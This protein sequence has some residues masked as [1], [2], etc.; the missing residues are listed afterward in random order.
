MSKDRGGI[1]REPPQSETAGVFS[2]EDPTRVFSQL[3]ELGHGAFGA[4]YQAV[5][6][7]GSTVAIKQMKVS[8]G[9]ASEEWQEILKEV[10][11]L[12]SCRHEHILEYKGCYRVGLTVWLVMECCIGSV[13]DIMDVFKAPLSEDEIAVITTCVLK[14]LDYLHQNSRMHRDIKGG[15][16]L[17][18]EAGGVRLG[19]FGS[20]TM[21]E[22]ANSF[23]GS[24]YWMAPEVIVAM[25]SGTYDGKVD[26][27][28]LGITCIEMAQRKPP[29]FE[30]QAMS[31]LYHIPQSEPPTLAD[32]AAWSVKFGEFVA[33]CL[34]MD[35]DKR[36]TSAALLEHEFLRIPRKPKVLQSLAARAKDP[37]LLQDNQ[38]ALERA[39]QQAASVVQATTSLSVNTPSSSSSNP[40]TAAPAETAT[41]KTK[42]ADSSAAPVSAP[43]ATSEATSAAAVAARAIAE[44]IAEELPPV[45]N[46]LAAKAKRMIETP[47]Q[48]ARSLRRKKNQKKQVENEL[49]VKQL[50]EIKKIR[51][52]QLQ[53]VKALQT[54]QDTDLIRQ[55]TADTREY[56]SL[57][58]SHEK[59]MEKLFAKQALETEDHNKTETAEE[60]A[61]Q[62]AIKDDQKHA[63]AAFQ[64]KFERDYKAAKETF[65]LQTPV[66]GGDFKAKKRSF[67]ESQE[68]EKT[69]AAEL[70]NGVLETKE[71]VSVLAFR[72]SRL[73][74]KQ[75]L[76][77]RHVQEELALRRQHSAQLVE[78]KQKRLLG[79]ETLMRAQLEER[80]ALQVA[81]ADRLTEVEGEQHDA[82]CK[83]KLKALKKAHVAELK[84][85]PK[86]LRQREDQ[87]RKSYTDTVKLQAKQ[88][89][90]LARQ[91]TERLPK[92]EQF[93]SLQRHKAE[94]TLKHA[95][96]EEDY[97]VALQELN[98]TLTDKLREV[99]EE[100][101]QQ[102][103]EELEAARGQLDTYQ[104]M[105]RD[106][107]LAKHRHMLAYMD[108]QRGA[109]AEELVIFE[110]SQKT[111][112]REASRKLEQLDADHAEETADLT[113]RLAV[114]QAEYDKM[115]AM[116]PDLDW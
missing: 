4:V 21:S 47:L 20:G 91:L 92:A 65:K 5:D 13:C 68:H 29:L 44:T 76:E 15:N 34:V 6:R 49:V 85:Q 12:G 113:Q 99:H 98:S 78:F 105:R 104:Q 100:E 97:R 50:S 51:K 32:P 90:A 57:R 108:K 112:N 95:R 70:L 18:T 7:D 1:L 40:A 38:E 81:H 88:A 63:R 14:G 53:E 10:R 8:K 101:E 52:A 22:R 79:L 9:F 46:E 86:E 66:K 54:R 28:S 30:M 23:I 31:A 17:L 111:H 27:W 39:F 77:Q 56:E 102:L 59:D 67:K 73:P 96:L 72:V 62:K 41:S 94:Q 55:S 74:M 93:S 64:Q 19:D 37:A 114:M 60:K 42:A 87:I 58:R 36:P 43:A 3:S 61:Q 84:R 110:E 107:T 45:E 82:V 75:A 48:R 33:D 71:S 25:E 106:N 16:I 35:P 83:T 69:Q 2:P 24:P 103:K 80:H 116:A 26:I 109:L 115:K 11:I 89:K